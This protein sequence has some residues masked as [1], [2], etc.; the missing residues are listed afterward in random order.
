MRI[1]KTSQT[2]PV[3][4]QVINTYSSSQTDTYSCDYANDN[5]QMN[6]TVLYNDATGSNTNLTLSDSAANYT[7]L[8]IF[9]RS[10]DN[11]FNSTK[12]YEPN[13]KTFLAM[14]LRPTGST[15]ASP[16]YLKAEEFSINGTSISKGNYVEMNFQTNGTFTIGTNNVM[17]ITRVVGYN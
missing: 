17:Y 8:E 15:T 3:Q 10:N 14:G 12:V 7:Y 4:A 2:T 13:G 1:K 5:F 9:F 6:G 11:V 16:V